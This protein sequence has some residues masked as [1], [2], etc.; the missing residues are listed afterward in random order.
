MRRLG[1]LLL[2]ILLGLV[3]LEAGLRVGGWVY[4]SRHSRSLVENA[5]RAILCLGDSH[6]FGMFLAKEDS[7]PARLESRLAGASAET[8]IAV[9]NRGVPGMSSLD[10]LGR[11]RELAALRRYEAVFVMVGANDRWK[12][13]SR[14]TGASWLARLQIVKFARV[15]AATLSPPPAPRV[16]STDGVVRPDDVAGVEKPGDAGA[17]TVALVDRAGD[18]VRF[19]HSITGEQEET[20]ALRGKLARNLDAL[21]EAVRAL[22]SE[23]WLLGYPSNHGDLALVNATLRD[24]ARR[25]G[26]RFVDLA[27]AVDE[28]GY[29]AAL[30]EDALFF[31]DRHPRASACE[32]VARVLRNELIDAGIATGERVADLTRDL[33]RAAVREAPLELAGAVGSKDLTVLVRTDPGRGV[34]VF[35]SWADGPPSDVLG[36]RIP[37]A[38]DALF[39]RT[40]APEQPTRA[41]AGD[42]GIARVPI[43]ALLGE[44]AHA[45]RTLWAVAAL[46]GRDG[47][48]GF[49]DL[50]PAASWKLR[51]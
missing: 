5:P 27:A 16:A 31:P 42:D 34:Y 11:A 39:E 10:V 18:V 3:L 47:A 9:E 8:S 23:P 29:R 46:L 20:D 35:L 37:I 44:E 2:A 6:T 48:P 30:S 40:L 28:V 4:L 7:W 22:G 25:H 49:H 13:P 21:V 17:A 24:A 38:R 15:L 43:G 45:G 19:D 1:K 50:T 36:V 32:I 26:A 14:S 33:P 51:P 12:G 41:V